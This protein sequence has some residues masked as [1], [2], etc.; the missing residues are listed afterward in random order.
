[1]IAPRLAAKARLKWD[2]REQRYL[3]LYPERGLS[4]SDSAA[5]ILKLCDGVHSLDAIVAELARA[6]NTD[7]AAVRR[8][9]TAFLEEMRKRGLIESG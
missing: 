1:V 4:L 5:A 8:D 7:E 3:L 2:R 6:G 9:V